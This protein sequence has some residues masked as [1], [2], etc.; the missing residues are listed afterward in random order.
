MGIRSFAL[1]SLVSLAGLGSGTEVSAPQE[2]DSK[3]PPAGAPWCMDFAEARAA[4]LEAGKP[5]FLY[6]TK[7][8]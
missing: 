7:T 2:S 3:T 6:S 5:I 8:Y 4:A 1:A